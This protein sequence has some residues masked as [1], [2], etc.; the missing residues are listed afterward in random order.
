MVLSGLGEAAAATDA[1]AEALA[2][3]L[4]LGIPDDIGRAYVNTA[5]SI[6]SWTASRAGAGIIARGH[7]GRF[8]LG[9]RT[10]YG[11]LHRRWRG[12]LRLRGG[13]WAEGST[14]WPKRPQATP[15]DGTDVYRSAYVM[16]LLACRGDEDLA[17]ME[18]AHGLV[19]ERPPRTTTG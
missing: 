15:I 8:R 2:I 12:V 13:P 6:E 10:S 19:L 7:A 4:E 3:A 17:A 1:I 9:R 18:R 5:P 11:V 16:E 14:S